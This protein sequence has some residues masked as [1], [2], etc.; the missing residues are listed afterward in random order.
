MGEKRKRLTPELTRAFLQELNDMP[1]AQATVATVFTTTQALCRKHRLIAY[2]AAYLELA[3]RLAQ[4]L[5]T[6]D[7]DLLTAAQAQRV[8]IL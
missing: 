6:V 5:A 8:R 7:E 2:D 3:I 4:P 1:V